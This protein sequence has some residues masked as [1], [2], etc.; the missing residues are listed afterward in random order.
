MSMIFWNWLKTNI[1]I[2]ISLM[3]KNVFKGY[4]K[5]AITLEDVSLCNIKIFSSYILF[6]LIPADSGAYT[7]KICNIHS[8]INFT[9]NLEVSGKYCIIH[10]FFAS[11]HS[12]L[13]DSIPSAPIITEG[14]PKYL[15]VL[16]NTTNV[17]FDCPIYRL[18]MEIDYL[19]LTAFLYVRHA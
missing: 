10:A 18:V 12:H 14:Y 7:C 5:W 15:T 16:K 11:W 9:T 13:R 1:V 19:R 4:I 17:Q 8:C 6:Q 3:F 2:N